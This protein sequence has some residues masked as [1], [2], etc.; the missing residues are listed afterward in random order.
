MSKE[1]GTVEVTAD[2]LEELCHGY[3]VGGVHELRD[4]YVIR[5]L[6]QEFGHADIVQTS[7]IVII[8]EELRHRDVVR[9]LVEEG[10]NTAVQEFVELI[11]VVQWSANLRIAFG[12]A[13]S[14]VYTR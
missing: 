5:S 6:V 1:L 3:I 14:V 11:I 12:M 8:R 2:L 10:A 7:F 9:D 13:A 4:R